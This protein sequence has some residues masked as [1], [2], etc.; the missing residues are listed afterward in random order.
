MAPKRFECEPRKRV[1]YIAAFE[2]IRYYGAKLKDFKWKKF[3]VSANEMKEIWHFAYV[4]AIG[5]SGLDI[6]Y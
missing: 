3:N 1:V 2:A 6:I 5:K 4:D